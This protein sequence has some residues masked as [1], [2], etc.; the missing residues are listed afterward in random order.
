MYLYI[1]VEVPK[2]TLITPKGV[3]AV[4]I[5][6]RYV[7]YG[8]SQWIRKGEAP[9]EKA[10]ML[11]ELAEHPTKRRSTT[12]YPPWRKGEKLQA[13]ICH[14]YKK[15]RNIVE[16]WAKKTAKRIVE[17]ARERQCAIAVENLI[18]FSRDD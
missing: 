7:Y 11:R 9:V 1:A 6:E 4:D 3:I 13:R 10:A 8:N 14:F 15:A 16:D 12:R 2:P 18:W 5:N 17:E